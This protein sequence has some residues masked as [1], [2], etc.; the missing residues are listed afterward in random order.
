MGHQRWTIVLYSFISSFGIHFLFLRNG[1]IKM[2]GHN[3][4]VYL[5]ANFTDL[6]M[7]FKDF[8]ERN[9]IKVREAEEIPLDPWTKRRSAKRIEAMRQSVE[10]RRLKFF[11]TSLRNK[12]MRNSLRKSVPSFI[13]GESHFYH[14][15]AINH[16][17]RH[18]KFFTFYIVCNAE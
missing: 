10:V 9:G 11:N 5:A 7:W 8:L 3:Y 14:F 1:L 12:T 13:K 16:F 6:L 17:Q 18:L 4:D 2:F 15:K